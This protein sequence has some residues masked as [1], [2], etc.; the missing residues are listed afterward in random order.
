MRSCRLGKDFEDPDERRRPNATT[1]LRCV[2][3]YVANHT[4]WCELHFTPMALDMAFGT[5]W[6]HLPVAVFHMDRLPEM[7][8]YLGRGNV[9]ARNS[10]KGKYRAVDVLRNATAD[11]M[12]DH[13]LELVCRMY[14]VDV[15]MM[16][17]MGYETPRCDKWLGTAGNWT[18]SLSRN[19][20]WATERA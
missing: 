17:S 9:H 4:F 2:A 15:L 3:D 13:T 19:R 10:K 12:D 7:L 1:A 20:S 18:R 8:R 5:L 14:E 6:R 16:R 11:D